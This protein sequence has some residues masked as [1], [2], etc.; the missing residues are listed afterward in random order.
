MR[1]HDVASARL[2]MLPKVSFFDYPFIFD[3][4][5]KSRIMHIDAVVQM[6]QS[7]RSGARGRSAGTRFCL[8]GHRQI[9]LIVHIFLFERLRER[10]G[11]LRAAH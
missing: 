4:A 7:M 11:N 2:A 10:A 9:G 6:S 8:V 3:A 1:R 5:S